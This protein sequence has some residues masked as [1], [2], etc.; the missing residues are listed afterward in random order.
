MNFL[1]MWPLIFS[2][3]IPA[4]ILLYILKRK[5]VEHKVSSS[6]LWM[7]IYK[8]TQANTPWEKFKNNIMLILQLIIIISTIFALMSPF[9]NFGGESYKNL[10]VVIDNSASMSAIYDKDSRLEVGKDMVCDYIKSNKDGTNAY[11]ISSN[12][13][14]NLEVS[15]SRDKNYVLKKIEE[16]SQ[17]Y[18]SGNIENS[19]SLIKSIGQSIGEDYEVLFITDKTIDMGDINGKVISLGNKGLNGS[20]ENISHKIT[21]DGVKVIAN[22]KNSGEGVYEGDFSLYSGNDNLVEVKSVS[23]PENQS[24]TLYFHLKNLKDEYIKGELST[25]DLIINDNVFYDIV[26]S[27][28]N[29]KI[30]L[31]TDKNIFLEKSLSTLLNADLYK[32]SDLSNI[33]YDDKYDLYIFDGKIPDNLPKEGNI[34]FINCNSNEFF[35]VNGEVEGGNATA[36]K[37]NISKYLNNMSFGVSKFKDI[38]LP[39]WGKKLIEVNDKP[40]AFW[41]DVNGKKIG[42]LTFDIHNSDLPLK[43]DFPILMHYLGEKLLDFG[44]VNKNNFTGSEEIVIKGKGLSED[45]K[46]TYPS[47]LKEILKDRTFENIYEL[48][49]Y[50]IEQ[51]NEKGDLN[52]QL[53]SLNFPKEEGNTLNNEVKDSEIKGFSKSIKKGL[54]LTPFLILFILIIVSIEWYFYRKGY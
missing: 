53:I 43:S 17:S 4:L 48:G 9:L 49:I 31:A 33:N 42:V 7:E 19:F 1:R 23:I 20:I 16:I 38:E 36:I 22:I 26:D 47:G 45:I 24:I 11:V 6:M 32:A 12:K 2:I 3:L 54:D 46:V 5:T 51:K 44:M 39:G 13:N 14:V 35:K 8:N 29:K 10:I 40:I 15:S 18:T 21:E 52:K 41:G 27:T 37:E 30:L 25:K 50:S 34:L 28:E